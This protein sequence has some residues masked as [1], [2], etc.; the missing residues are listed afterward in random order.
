MFEVSALTRRAGWVGKQVRRLRKKD[1]ESTPISRQNAA[2]GSLKPQTSNI[3]LKH[4]TNLQRHI[5]K[6][7]LRA[8]VALKKH[9]GFTD[10]RRG[11]FN[12]LSCHHFAEIADELE[13]AALCAV[14]GHC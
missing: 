11:F 8:P 3:F 7:H 9:C 13:L 12:L 5:Q 14:D 2:L 4:R 6:Y 10:Q 1:I